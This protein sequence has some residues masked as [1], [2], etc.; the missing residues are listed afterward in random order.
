MSYIL[1]RKKKGENKEEEEKYKR[2]KK[3]IKL[4]ETVRRRRKKNRK[5]RAGHQTSLSLKFTLPS[6]FFLSFFCFSLLFFCR[7]HTT[8]PISWNPRDD[9]KETTPAAEPFPNQVL[10]S[11]SIPMNRH[12]HINGEWVVTVSN[13]ANKPCY[14][15][16]DLLRIITIKRTTNLP[17]RGCPLQLKTE[18][19]FVHDVIQLLLHFFVT[20]LVRTK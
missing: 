18:I 14:Y 11:I 9:E 3:S 20:S 10:H 12:W 17:L 6:R 13:I 16:N 8:I 19:I 4:K 1:Y 7:K 15:T 2:M 5:D